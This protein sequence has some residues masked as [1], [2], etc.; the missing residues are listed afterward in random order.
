[1]ETRKA[2]TALGSALP[3]LVWAFV[4]ILLGRGEA[5]TIWAPVFVIVVGLALWALY[6]VFVEPRLHPTSDELQDAL[7]KM[8]NYRYLTD[9]ED[10]Q[11][12]PAEG[13]SNEQLFVRHAPSS[14]REF[15]YEELGLP[16]PKPR[17]ERAR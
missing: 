7:D 9:G 12:K 1:M 11:I 2:L 13:L 15:W 17:R 16:K 8:I 10:R 5:V 3:G 6:W 4:P 14:V